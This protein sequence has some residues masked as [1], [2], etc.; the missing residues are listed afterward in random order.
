MTMSGSSSG[1]GRKWI[2]GTVIA[3]TSL[4]LLLGSASGASAF[5][6]DDVQ[7]EAD[8]LQ[9]S[10]TTVE[11]DSPNQQA[12]WTDKDDVSDWQVLVNDEDARR[13]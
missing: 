3:A 12:A 7:L 5:L 4:G 13:Q 2:R 6:A 1:R 11:G 9:L 10:Q 8:S